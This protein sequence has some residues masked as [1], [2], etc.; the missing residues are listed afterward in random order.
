MLNAKKAEET[1]K[2]V[3]QINKSYFEHVSEVGQQMTDASSS[4]YVNIKFPNINEPF[5]S[6]VEL[7]KKVVNQLICQHLQREGLTQSYE[8]FLKES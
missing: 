6:D 5:V 3:V 7:D 2:N 8:A 4:K 1:F